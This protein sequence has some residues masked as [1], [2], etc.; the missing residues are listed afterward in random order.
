MTQSSRLFSVLVCVP[1]STSLSP[2]LLCLPP[3]T[4]KGYLLE[5]HGSINNFSPFDLVGALGV[6]QPLRR[7]LPGLM[8]R[9]QQ[10]HLWHLGCG[11]V[12]SFFGRETLGPVLSLFL[13]G[14]FSGTFPKDFCT[15]YILS[16]LTY[17]LFLLISTMQG[18]VGGN[19]L[20]KGSWWLWHDCPPHPNV[21][22]LLSTYYTPG[23]M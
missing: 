13:S 7:R 3:V 20:C 8:P 18:A 6:L 23:S 21:C 17:K 19:S 2:P 10:P 5:E 16:L 11:K 9:P 4:H 1:S 22:Y 14:A 15:Y 12:I